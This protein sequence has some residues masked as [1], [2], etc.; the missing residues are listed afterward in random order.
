MGPHFFFFCHCPHL[1]PVINFFFF[2]FFYKTERD[3]SFLF[4]KSDFTLPFLLFFLSSSSYPGFVVLCS[5]NSSPNSSCSLCV[6]E[7]LPVVNLSLAKGKKKRKKKIPFSSPSLDLMS[8]CCS[9]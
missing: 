8:C 6:A 3:F 2:F 4:L 9:C 5:S 7:V 1:D